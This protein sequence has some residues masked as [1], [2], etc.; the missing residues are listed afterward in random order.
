MKQR[1]SDEPTHKMKNKDDKFLD[2]TLSI[3]EP[4]GNY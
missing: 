3:Y 4:L 2:K 1:W